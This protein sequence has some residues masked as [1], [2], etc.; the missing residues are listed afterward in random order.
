MTRMVPSLD[1]LA[2][3][4][5][6]GHRF[7]VVAASVV[8]DG[9]TPLSCFARL[10]A[11]P[12]GAFL[13]ESVEGGE[14]TGRWSFFGSGLQP[15]LRVDEGGAS[16][17]RDGVRLR[18]ERALLGELRAALFEARAFVPEG[19]PPFTGGLVGHI[20][21]DAL[22]RFEPVPLAAPRADAGA[23]VEL[24][25]ADA[26]YAYDHATH[27][28]HALARIPLDG[29]LEDRR[30]EATAALEQR[31][32]RMTEPVR[33]RPFGLPTDPTEGLETECNH[34]AESFQAAVRTA[35]EAI[36]DGEIF[37]VVLSARFT[38]RQPV[39]PLALYRA[40]RAL[41]PSPYM[42]L[43]RP[44]EGPALVGASPEVLVSVE[45]GEVLVRPIAGTRRR[46]RT[47]KEDLELERE[48]LADAKERAEH[49]MLLD[50]GR[51]DVGRVARPGT[52]RVEAPMHI[53]RYAH[54][55]HIVSDVHG[56]LAAGKDAVDALRAG[57]PA[58]TVCGAPKLRAAEIIAQL[59]PERRGTYAG[60][61][62]YFDPAGGMD[63]C[64]AIRTAVVHPDRVEVQAGAGIVHD[65]DPAL[66]W[67]EV[68][69]KARSPLSAIG[70]ALSGRT[71]VGEAP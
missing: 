12:G 17:F 10:D 35:K 30:A 43:L 55:M 28:L 71:R 20:A 59:E 21:F 66:E 33:L 9:E 29:R 53:E 67:K 68:C 4:K 26:P 5:A 15:A 16:R 37:Q 54:V 61:V 25:M 60:A 46:G 24:M 64:I 69:N 56:T 63:T 38:V 41:N 44:T 50:L 48:L 65:S 18:G 51:N 36:L 40:L 6:A 13:F 11:D 39:E 32:S 7:A 58:G 45:K 22:S 23:E 1:E 19:L 49:T 8:A 52:V 62:G 42:F 3:A 47:T 27:T 2:A 57:F 14:R 70:V 34:D 31:L